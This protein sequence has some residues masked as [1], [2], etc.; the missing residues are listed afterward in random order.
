MLTRIVV[1][2]LSVRE[3]LYLIPEE[4]MKKIDDKLFADYVYCPVNESRLHSKDAKIQFVA[5]VC[6]TV[7]LFRKYANIF[8]S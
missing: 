3:T 6:V 7:F 5:L 4:Q 8:R 2:V 1:T